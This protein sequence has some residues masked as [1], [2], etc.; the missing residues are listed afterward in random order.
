MQMRSLIRQFGAAVLAMAIGLT[1]GPAQAEVRIKDIANFEGVRENHLIGYGLVVGLLG[2]GDK[3]NSSPFTRESIR[4][5]LE[6]LGVANLDGAALKTKNTAAVMVTAKLPPFARRGSPIDI[7]V[8]SLGDA[9]SLRGGTLLV[10]PLTGADGAVYAVAQGAVATSGYRVDGNAASVV[11]GVPTI[12][13]IENGAIVEREIDFNLFQLDSVRIALH[14]PDFTTAARVHDAIENRLGNGAAEVLDSGTVEVWIGGK[15]NVPD[16]MMTVENLTVTPDAIARVVVDEKSGTIVMGADV[17]IGQVA[18]SQGG[19]TVRIQENFNVSQ[20]GP[21]SVGGGT[22]VITGAPISI[23]GSTVVV[24]ETEIDIAESDG[25]FT[26]L[27]GDVSLEEL[28]NGL[29]AIGV[30]ARQTIAILQAIKA[31][32]ALHADL[33]II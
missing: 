3:L 8:S 11:E 10:T 21:V 14:N 13:K 18:I 4:G 27:R 19:L 15:G 28:V 17:R 29:N 31:A 30:G 12:A 2:S 22:A 9:T 33:E 7:T 24:P 16:T 32:G 23:G 6:R 20:P 26:I 5:M 25:S 1:G